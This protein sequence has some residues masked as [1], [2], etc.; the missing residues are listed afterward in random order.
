MSRVIAS[1]LEDEGYH[2]VTCMTL[3]MAR[4]ALERVNVSVVVLDLS[5]GPDFATA[6]LDELAARED[7]PAVVVCS[8]FPL[9]EMVAARY[10]LTAVR[11][12][13][14]LTTL[15]AAVDRAVENHEQPRRAAG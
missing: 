5:L 8:G 6:L 15:L 7:A 11:K 14:E 1:A 12:P 3:E 13:F 9:A 4:T 10:G 2:P